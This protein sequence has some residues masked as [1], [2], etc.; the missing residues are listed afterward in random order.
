MIFAVDVIEY[1]SITITQYLGGGSYGNVHMG[2]WQCETV[3]I[4]QLTCNALTR[5]SHNEFKRE[6]DVWKYGFLFR[7]IKIYIF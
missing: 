4:K 7:M 5:D 6:V 1:S 3:A 2:K